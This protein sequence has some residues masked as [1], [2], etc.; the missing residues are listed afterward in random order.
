MS[1]RITMPQLGETVTEGTILRWLVKV[2]DE[3]KEDDP[4]L[5]IS[6]DKVDTEVPSPFNGIVSALLVEEGETVE[7]GSP[8]LELDGTSTE[9]L[10]A[11]ATES[12]EQEDKIEKTEIAPQETFENEQTVTESKIIQSTQA[13]GKV[14]PVVR[15]LASET[16]SYTHLPLPTILRV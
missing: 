11:E 8:L 9:N 6:T 2:G 14:S 1:E 4:I 15:K 3:I 12:V 7:V 10:N 13:L 5:E 16:V